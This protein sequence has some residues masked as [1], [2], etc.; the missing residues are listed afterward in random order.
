MKKLY[1]PRS[2]TA[3]HVPEAPS[4]DRRA[5]ACLGRISWRSE[6]FWLLERYRGRVAYW[7]FFWST[8]L[9]RPSQFR[10]G[11]EL[12]ILGYHFR[13]VARQL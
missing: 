12:A 2:L 6:I 10:R 8:L 9:R 5:C 11:I 3:A 13:R 1:E 7:Q 4:P